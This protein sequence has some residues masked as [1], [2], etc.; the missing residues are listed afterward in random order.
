[1]VHND[2]SGTVTGTVVQTGAM[3]VH[4]PR[5]TF[6]IRP[7]A[8]PERPDAAELRQQP[9][10]LLLARN[11]V[12][13]FTGREHE[14]A[15]LADWRRARSKVSALLL[16][17][18]G[19]QGK[20]RLAAEFAAQSAKAK[21]A[22]A[23][24]HHG[25]EPGF[26]VDNEV[27]PTGALGLLLVVD[28]AERWPR[29]D[30]L[31]LFKDK[32]LRHSGPTRILLLARTGQRWWDLLRYPLHKLGISTDAK[33]LT[34]LAAGVGSRRRVFESARDR[35]AEVL[36][37]DAAGVRPVGSM[38]DPAYRSVLTIHMAALVAV[39][40][41]GR[42]LS[43]P[44]N[45]GALSR[46]L[47]DREMD[48]WAG[49]REGGSI[50]S[51]PES[52]GRAAFV[53]TLTGPM[54][55]REGS[56][57]L[58]RVGL[59]ASEAEAARILADHSACYPPS[60]GDT[61]LEPLCPD[62]LGEDFLAYC[63]PGGSS[64][65]NRA[66]G[67]VD[68]WT[69]DAP[70]R[71]LSATGRDLPTLRRGQMITVLAETSRR[72]KH[73]HR[74]LHTLLS[75][76]PA[77][78]VA[79]GGAALTAVANIADIDIGL[80]EA[81]EPYLPDHHVDLDL[82]SARLAQRLTKYRLDNTRCQATHAQLLTDL[83]WRL[84][85]AGAFD[86]ALKATEP[87]VRIYRRLAADQPS[88]FEPGLAQALH[89]L[90]THRAG[91]GL[92]EAALAVSEEAV[93][94]RKRLVATNPAAHEPTLASSLNNLAMDLAAVGLREAALAASEEAVAIRKRLAAT[95]PAAHE[96]TLAS[97][98]NNLGMR[99]S[100][101]ER[102]EAALSAAE[103]AVELYRSLAAG[104]PAAFDPDLAG[105]LH[106]LGQH[107]SELGKRTEALA[108]TKEAVVIRERLATAN[109]AV[110]EADLA[111]SL[112]NLAAAYSEVGLTEHALA[113]VDQAVEHYWRLVAVN[114][115]VYDAELAGCL[116][117]QGVLLARAG[118]P[119]NAVAATQHAVTIR[120]RLTEIRVT[121]YELQLIDTLKGLGVRL[122]GPSRRGEAPPKTDRVVVSLQRSVDAI[123]SAG[124]P[125]AARSTDN[126][127]TRLARAARLTTAIA[128][129]N[130]RAASRLKL[131]ETALASC[132]A[133]MARSLS[134][135][136]A[137]LADI[138]RQAEALAAAEQA[139]E[140]YRRLTTANPAVHRSAFASALTNLGM[141]LAEFGR[142]D[143]ALAATSCALAVLELPATIK[144]GRPSPHLARVLQAF[145]WVRM[146]TMLELD[147]ALAAVQ[148]SEQLYRE[149][150]AA[151]SSAF[152][153]ELRS[154]M[155]THAAVLNGLGR[156]AEAIT[157]RRRAN[158]V[159]APPVRST[160]R[161]ALSSA[162]A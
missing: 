16:D 128:S 116:H 89:H 90:G 50:T 112:R 113:S 156:V 119:R 56:A 125:S 52:L 127:E 105:A 25:G 145:A 98:L 2:I 64:G 14:L 110:F 47:L 11:E 160:H 108:A 12:V 132:E 130:P 33:G 48:H 103:E 154:A 81:I 79:A 102:T 134:N 147:A 27:D 54:T 94:I 146:A 80:L 104:N 93:A 123:L 18:P 109:P 118:R 17:G 99:L 43:P 10:Q 7:F 95:N 61:V 57:V 41:A 86:Q 9:S 78:V 55:H 151:D 1:V 46:Y 40:A 122:P 13:E 87:A 83:G 58:Q 144:P 138:G 131:A 68:P 91:A 155:D 85:N 92:H 142:R 73:V 44:D 5:H 26:S 159:T 34:E 21:W 60:D 70:S 59:A 36:G 161:T 67:L 133:Q 148:R 106:N 117:N 75:G 114:P 141:R 121:S 37:V 15:M 65:A 74:H 149:L 150:M 97:S 136:S 76:N 139:A 24:A 143:E 96:P 38:K 32:R 51:S 28:Y 107:R 126:L 129:T 35:F 124:T 53:A 69:E 62:R 120:S 22:V 45:P 153:I 31:A 101:V 39:D 8:G 72:W 30:L 77:G 71:L 42:R 84:G 162:R 20:T 23:V 19:G 152:A 63:L 4:Q 140:S 3:H 115:E 88:V 158:S 137:N 66:S 135:L 100:G 6:C 157:V 111:L 82:A 29:G 49:M